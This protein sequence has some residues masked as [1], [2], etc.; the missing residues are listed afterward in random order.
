MIDL[1]IISIDCKSARRKSQGT[2]LWADN[3]YCPVCSMSCTRTLSTSG[4]KV[5]MSGAGMVNED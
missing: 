5:C 3:F 1:R 2:D 4:S